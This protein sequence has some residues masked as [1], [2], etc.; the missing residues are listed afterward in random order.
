[1][2]APRAVTMMI[3]FSF[4]L[5]SLGSL[6]CSR[7]RGLKREAARPGRNQPGQWLDNEEFPPAELACLAIMT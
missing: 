4:Y 1:M 5:G 7:C 3:E 6:C 2:A